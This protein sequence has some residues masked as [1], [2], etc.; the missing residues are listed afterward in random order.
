L[1]PGDKILR[2]DGYPVTRFSGIG[3]SI[4]WRVVSSEGETLAVEVERDGEVRQFD[5]AYT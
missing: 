5:T 3:D 1:L 4:M 2:I